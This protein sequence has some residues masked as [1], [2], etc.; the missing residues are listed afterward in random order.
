[1]VDAPYH[2]VL[3]MGGQA[4]REPK[5]LHVEDGRRPD[6]QVVFPRSTRSH[7]R[8]CL[9]SAVFSTVETCSVGGSAA[10]ALGSVAT[11][12]EKEVLGDGDAS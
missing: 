11:E 12:E 9:S 4:V 6:L 8:R 7:R 2:A 5:G 10:V 3:I 1:M